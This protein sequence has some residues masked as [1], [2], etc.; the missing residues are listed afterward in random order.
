[1]LN[2]HVFP[3]LQ[4][5]GGRAIKKNDAEGHQSWRG[6]GGQSSKRVWNAV[7][8]VS[9]EM[10]TPSA[11]LKVASQHFLD[12]ALA[13]TLSQRHCNWILKNPQWKLNIRNCKIQ[14]VGS[15]Q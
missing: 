15:R 3:S 12:G 6:R 13:E 2:K 14:I 10:T 9:S 8:D 7:R 11:L 4:R 5:R 1:M